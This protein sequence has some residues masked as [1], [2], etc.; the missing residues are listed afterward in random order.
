MD[1]RVVVFPTEV[2]YIVLVTL[3]DAK[4]AH[5]RVEDIPHE[6]DSVVTSRGQIL[7][8]PAKLNAVDFAF[9]ARELDSRRH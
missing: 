1:L 9:V 4:V 2:Q 8:T 3:A 7:S 5:L 6:R